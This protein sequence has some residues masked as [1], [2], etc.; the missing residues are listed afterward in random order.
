MADDQGLLF[1]A[2]AIMPEGFAYRADFI[3]AAEEAALMAV[4]AHLPFEPFQFQQYVG[5]RKVIYFGWRYDFTRGEVGKAD[6]MPDFLKPLR[7]RVAD[8][9]GVAPEAFE[10]ALINAYEPGAPLGWHKDRPQ[11]G[12][13]AGVSLGAPVR[14]RMRLKAGE[15][16]ER[17]TQV[18]AP[19]SAYL[20]RG[21]AR[22]QWEHSLP[23]AE[24]LRYSVTFRTL[25][26][27]TAKP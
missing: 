26:S 5:L 7:A 21:P 19:R 15:G 17:R 14:F 27:A 6:E 23:P 25:R 8:F 16:W 11:F 12:D 20:L 18:L 22:W 24:G 13:V 2:P 10:H 9:A 4:L 3:S 1:E